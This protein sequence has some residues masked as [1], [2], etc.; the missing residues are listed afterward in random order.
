LK[1]G[2][3]LAA[4]RTFDIFSNK[5]I[6]IR[7]I[8]G[9]YPKSI[10]ATFCEDIML[11]NRSN[12][13]IIE[14]PGSTISLKYILGILNSNVMAYYF[15]KYT[16]KAVRQM[17]PKLILQDL[18][19]FPIRISDNQLP[20][21]EKVDCMLDGYNRFHRATDSLIQLLKSKWSHLTITAKISAWDTLSFEEFRKELEKQKIK[22]SLQ[23]Q[24]EWLDYFSGQKQKA[25]A[26]LFFL[27]KT[28]K[29]IDQMV[30]ELYGLTGE[31][32]KIIE[33]ME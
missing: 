26:I 27:D 2:D 3:H 25:E 5:K 18:R 12:I 33:G 8:T 32:I 29:E 23:E 7:E 13:V 10:I 11:F 4:P 20:L 28:D 21:I 9:T 19:R 22:L 1:Y 15:V 16:P 6:I 31:E 24:A 14:K 30:Y 17:F